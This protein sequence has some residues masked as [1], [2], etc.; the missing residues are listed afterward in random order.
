M[1]LGAAWA[2]LGKFIRLV[3]QPV[4][5]GFI[6]GLALMV[7]HS[8][9]ESFKSEMGDWLPQ[10]ELTVMCILTAITMAI[11]FTWERVGKAVPAPLMAVCILT[12]IVSFTGV[13]TGTVG[14]LA[15]ISGGLPTFHLPQVPLTFGAAQAV[16]PVALSLASVGLIQTLL[17]QQ[18]VDELIDTRTQTNVECRGQGIA[19]VRSSTEPAH[20]AASAV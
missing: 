19:N 1:Q 16:V 7:A 14:D 13:S 10:P 12:G 18:L 17:T 9:L 15:E 11:I 3:P 6:N 2:Q 5:L 20:A 4:M 8:Q